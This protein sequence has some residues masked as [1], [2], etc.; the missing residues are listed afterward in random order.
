MAALESDSIDKVR[1]ASLQRDP[2]TQLRFAIEIDQVAVALFTE[3]SALSIETETLEYQEGGVNTYTHKLPTRT[4]YG[5]IT[6]KRGLDDTQELYQWYLNNINGQITRRNLSII[7]YDILGKSVR[8]WDLMGAYPCK[9]TGSDLR[10]DS[11]GIA[12]ET[13]ELAHSGLIPSG[14]SKSESLSGKG[15]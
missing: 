1:N 10:V 11:G 2:Y 6:L 7:M 15:R 5:N 12:I 3:C 13:I 4:K 8:R 9:W 14:P